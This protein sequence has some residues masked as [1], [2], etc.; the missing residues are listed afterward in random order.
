MFNFVYTQLN[1]KTVQFQTILLSISTQFISI[2]RID[3][4]LS[5]ATTSGESGSG[6]DSYK[7]VFRI[8]L[9]SNITGT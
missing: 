9:S 8:P 7:W 2:W 1:V 6:S 5:G 4:D 3:R